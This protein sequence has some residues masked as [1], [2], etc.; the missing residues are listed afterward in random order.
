[1]T[2]KLITNKSSIHDSS[3]HDFSKDNS[4]DPNQG[5]ITFDPSAFFFGGVHSQTFD[6]ADF[7]PSAPD[8]TP[9]ELINLTQKARDGKLQK[10]LFRD[11]ETLAL[12]KTLSRK[13]KSN[14]LLQG[15]AGVGKTQLVENLAIMM[16]NKEPL[17]IDMIGEYE[18]YELPLSN[19]VAGKGIVGQLEQAVKEIIEFLES[20]QAIV[21]ID[22]I[23]M[24]FDNRDTQTYSKIAQLLKPA[25]ARNLKTIGATTTSE[26]TNILKDPA[27]NRRFSTINVPELSIEQTSQ[28]LEMLM[29]DYEKHHNVVVPD[30]NKAKIIEAIIT[31]SE[32]YKKPN[33]H[34]P[35][36]AITLMDTAFAETRMRF[37][38]LQTPQG[39]TA[40]AHVVTTTD[41]KKSAISQFQLVEVTP[42]VI[43]NLKTQL[44]ANIIGQS[45]IKQTIVDTF[46]RQSL[47]LV[48]QKRPN[49]FLFAGPT[50]TG[51]TQI[52]REIAKSLFG[53]DESLIYIN[54]SEYSSHGDLNAI[55][56][57]PAGFVG[58]DDNTEL[59]LQPLNNNPFSIVLLD[60]FEK[61]HPDVQQ[62]FMQAFDYGKIKLKR[63]NEEI[64]TSRAVFI[65]T[66]NAGAQDFNKKTIGFGAT[67]TLSATE[68]STILEQ[69]FKPELLN[70]MTHKLVFE[71]ISKDDYTKILAVKYN[72]IVAEASELHPEYVLSPTNLDINNPDDMAL[73]KPITD[74]SY[75]P[76]ENG[77]PAEKTIQQY[78][79]SK[80][81]EQYNQTQISLF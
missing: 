53:T 2:L 57:S 20:Q 43:Q 9:E 28:I 45:T 50:G 31:Q 63:R 58:S 8:E 36:T 34:R 72:K 13:K 3:I 18:I 15:D 81:L 44:D 40:P 69:N 39:M 64:D 25:L 60:E 22:E 5:A 24:L 30:S 70:R 23:H 46:A 56:G 4:K 73:L 14:A 29:P 65:L 48:R 71:S 47:G 66:T 6:P 11:N 55:V 49:V 67:Q 7:Q 68:T 51:K 38:Q 1:M 61:A 52:A 33:N 26:G 19:L 37:N 27:I 74:I 75:N 80:L 16:A 42:D 41:I 21:F 59:P 76:N 10:A 78:I 35:D 17:V 54:M 77:R 32:L 12:I 62:F 79:E